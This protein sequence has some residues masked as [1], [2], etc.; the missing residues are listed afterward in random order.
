MPQDQTVK[1]NRFVTYKRIFTKFAIINLEN[2]FINI[3]ILGDSM[4]QEYIQPKSLEEALELISDPSK[5]TR[6]IAGGTDLI[7]EF[8]GKV[9]PEPELLV[10]I[11]RIAGLN[12]IALEDDLIHIG[13]LVTH[14]HV[15][16]SK[17]LQQYAVPLVQA[18]WQI[19]APQIRNRGTVAGNILTASPAN[20]TITPLV[21][22]DASVELRSSSSTRIIKMVD[23][24]KGVRKTVIRP[25]EILTDILIPAL[26]K[27]QKGSFYKQG[28]RKAQ[29]ISVV[30]AAVV[31][32]LDNGI[33]N[34]ASITLG[35]VSPTII[36]ADE[37]EIFLLGKELNFKVIEETAK[38]AAKA[39][40][41]IDDVRGSAAYRSYITEICV[42]RALR[43]L[44]PENNQDPVPEKP[45]LLW[46]N[47]NHKTSQ[48]HDTPSH[49]K[50]SEISF[51]VNGKQIISTHSHN[52]TLLSLLRDEAL[53]TGTKEGCGEGECGACTVYMDGKAV[54]SC[55]VPAPRAEGTEIITIEGLS[56]E[57]KLH[58]VQ[59]SFI[60]EDAVQCGY[61][62]P[63]FIMSAAK[64]L[65]EKSHPTEDEIKVAISGNLCRCTGY[66][67][68]L[69]AIENSVE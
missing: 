29:A 32:G 26:T 16:G 47:N 14:N 8:E 64:L 43:K 44:I 12:Q 41:P 28:L 53:M 59:Q 38:L 31:I 49:Q 15:V 25:D 34:K 3:E 61:C 57:G 39:A 23:F 19:G 52:K 4:W 63:G 22:M 48:L 67:K 17:L 30:N 1:I 40:T 58:P 11:T 5:R 37:A 6:V 18:C 9:S 10:D 42:K 62:T 46:G 51:K 54:M 65:E 66:K 20:D 13:P 35:S 21:A 56:H 68:I 2:S 69:K 33:I 50:G 55:L 60:E 27:G 24:F 36:H 7:L 45:V